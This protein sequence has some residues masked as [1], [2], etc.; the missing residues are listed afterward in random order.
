[1]LDHTSMHAQIKAQ[2][3]QMSQQGNVQNEAFTKGQTIDQ[4]MAKQASDFAKIQADKAMA[5]ESQ[6]ASK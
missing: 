4:I 2:Q 3:M 5:K 6:P 1:M